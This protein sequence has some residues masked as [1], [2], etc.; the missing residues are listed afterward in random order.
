VGVILSEFQKTE[1]DIVNQTSIA[2]GYFAKLV[3][4]LE[5]GLEDIQKQYASL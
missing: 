1:H 2:K 4:Q 3:K 5:T